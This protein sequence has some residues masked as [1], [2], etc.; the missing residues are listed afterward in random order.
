M[1]STA[2]TGKPSLMTVMFRRF[3]QLGTRVIIGCATALLAAVLIC[4]SPEIGIFGAVGGVVFG[5]ISAAL[6]HPHLPKR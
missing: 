6:F 5:G 4:A 1:I 2:S 3:S